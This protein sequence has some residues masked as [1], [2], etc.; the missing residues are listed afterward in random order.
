[1]HLFE[2]YSSACNMHVQ[3]RMV[4]LTKYNQLGTTVVLVLRDHH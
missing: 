2:L 4:V 3:S 1:M